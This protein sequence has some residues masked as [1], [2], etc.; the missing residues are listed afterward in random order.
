MLVSKKIGSP[1]VLLY[2]QSMWELTQNEFNKATELLAQ[3][4]VELSN[5]QIQ[6]GLAMEQLSIYEESAGTSMAPPLPEASGRR[7]LEEMRTAD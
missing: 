2:T 7:A 3:R 6:L 5:T 1:G 4:D